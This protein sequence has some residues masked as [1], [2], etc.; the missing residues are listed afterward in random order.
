M[1]TSIIEALQA[2]LAYELASHQQHWL[3]AQILEDLGHPGLAANWLEEAAEE[4]EHAHEIVHRLAFLGVSPTSERAPMRVGST[5]PEIMT[6]DAEA[7]AEGIGR[8]R[9]AAA[10]AL[11]A[12]DFG[13]YELTARLLATEERHLACVRAQIAQ[14][15]SMGEAGYAQRFAAA[16]GDD[17]SFTALRAVH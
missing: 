7:E 13:T 4:L 14:I 2:I 9:T 15:E 1:N 11:E 16:P 5:L 17:G 8:Y 3:H 12:Q 10:L 6:L